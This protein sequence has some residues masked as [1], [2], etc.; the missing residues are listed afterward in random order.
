MVVPMPRQSG[1][2]AARRNTAALA[3]S[4]AWAR[5]AAGRPSSWGAACFRASTKVS[6]AIRLATLP[7]LAPP[8]PSHTTPTASC[9][10][11]TS[12]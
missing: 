1:S 7:A 9:S 6:T 11:G 3:V 12:K 4:A 10:E 8:M 5:T 2:A